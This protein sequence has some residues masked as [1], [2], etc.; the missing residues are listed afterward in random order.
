MWKSWKQRLQS[1]NEK[2]PSRELPN[3]KMFLGSDGR[4]ENNSDNAFH[5]IFAWFKLSFLSQ[6]HLL[7]S[8]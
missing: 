8:M 3:F 5:V 2:V 7:A 6:S 1:L 4:E